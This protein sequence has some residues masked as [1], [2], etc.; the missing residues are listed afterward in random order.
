M[1]TQKMCHMRN[2]NLHKKNIYKRSLLLPTHNSIPPSPHP[3]HTHT[4]L[5]HMLTHTH[6]PALARL[7]TIPDLCT[8]RAHNQMANHSGTSWW[9]GCPK[10]PLICSLSVQGKLG[11]GGWGEGGELIWFILL[12]SLKE[13][14]L[15]TSVK[16]DG[17]NYFLGQ[18]VPIFDCSR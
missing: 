2:S 3:H 8:K 7:P 17:L 12:L 6:H 15:D 5:A 4:H 1:Y 13:E 16:G 14:A 18:A 11:W 10:D 9:G